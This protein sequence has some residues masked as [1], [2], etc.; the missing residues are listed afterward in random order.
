MELHRCAS[1]ARVAGEV[2]RNP[3]PRIHE[4]LALART[5]GLLHPDE[6][7]ESGSG[8]GDGSKVYLFNCE[9][10]TFEEVITQLVKA[11]PGMTRAAAEEIAWR[12]H[13]QGLAEVYRGGLPECERVAAI[14]AE[15]GLIV[16][17]L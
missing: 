2:S 13:T 10:H 5:G 3:M 15:I 17:V 7:V 12:V 1:R 4:R 8:A 11:V 16:Q 14:L 9:C 6:V